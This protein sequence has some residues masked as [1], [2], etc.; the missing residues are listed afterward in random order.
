MLSPSSRGGTCL[1]LSWHWYI[2]CA[3]S[4]KDKLNSSKSSDIFHSSQFWRFVFPSSQLTI[5]M[6]YV[7][8]PFVMSRMNTRPQFMAA[9]LI[10]AGAQ[11]SPGSWK[12]YRVCQME[13]IPFL[14]SYLLS[15]LYQLGM[16]LSLTM[17][18]PLLSLPC[19]VLGG[20]DNNHHLTTVEL[21]CEVFFRTLP[22]V[23]I[24]WIL[25]WQTKQRPSTW[26]T[27]PLSQ[28][29]WIGLTYGLG[30]GPVPFVTMSALFPQVLT[31]FI[32][33]RIGLVKKILKPFSL[34]KY[35]T[36]GMVA[37]QITRAMVI[38]LRF[39]HKN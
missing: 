26:T 19:L 39:H 28:S 36:H 37:G 34:Q 6:G 24:I 14:V 1:R 27:R 38:S 25:R 23:P 5:T 16:G 21:I 12:S 32:S 10:S 33:W 4:P 20:Q 2:R 18:C 31:L 17:P 7:F 8:S 13:I 29:Y 35:K 3:T 9:L 11:V 22:C 15:P 30:V